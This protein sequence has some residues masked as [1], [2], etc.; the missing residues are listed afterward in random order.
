MLGKNISSRGGEVT[1]K[2]ARAALLSSED[3]YYKLFNLTPDLVCIISNGTFVMINNAGAEML[4][5][6]SSGDMIGRSFEDFLHPDFRGLFGENLDCLAGEDGWFPLKMMR[7]G[8]DVFDSELRLTPFID[9]G[10]SSF[11]LAARDITA[12]R[13][14]AEVLI[15]R[16]ERLR[17]AKEEAEHGNRAKNEFIANISHEL[18]TPLNAI[19][20][21]SEI[22]ASQTFGP[23]GSPQYKNYIRDINKSGKNLLG[24]INDILDISAIESGCLDFCSESSDVAELVKSCLRMAKIRADRDKVVIRCKIGKDLPAIDTEPRRFKQ[25]ILNLLSN[26]IKFSSEGGL[27]DV[28]VRH[29]RKTGELVI[30]VRDSGIG[31]N[32]DEVSKVLVPFYQVDGRLARKYGGTGLGLALVKA[33]VDMHEGSIEIDSKPDVGTSVTVRLPFRNTS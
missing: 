25:I 2:P 14:A 21:F 29:L 18:R 33:F 24:V 4:G 19:I 1:D 10:E 20:G 11:M 13:Q 12:R 26:A 28:H 32:A 7:Q 3:I 9:G 6:G 15:N 22:M 27:V 5:V 31:M 16:E 8:G 17:Q 23:I 30:T